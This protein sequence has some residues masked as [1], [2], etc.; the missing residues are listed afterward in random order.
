MKRQLASLGASEGGATAIE[1][2][3]TAGLVALGLLTAYWTVGDS[4]RGGFAEIAGALRLEQPREDGR[5]IV[6]RT[7]PQRD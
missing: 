4:L 5:G 1:Y 7:S 2:G 6:V 3:L